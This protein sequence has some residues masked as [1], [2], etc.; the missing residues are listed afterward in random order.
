MVLRYFSQTLVRLSYIIREFLPNIVA[1]DLWGT[2]LTNSSVVLHSD[3]IAVVHIIN[4]NTS[5]DP[6]LM[7]LMRRLM[8]ASPTYDI[9]F[10]AEH[11]PGLHNTAADLLSRYRSPASGHCTL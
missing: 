1:M 3:N 7:K 10:S 5:K 6:N 2:T 9:Q 8:V 4:S 11:I